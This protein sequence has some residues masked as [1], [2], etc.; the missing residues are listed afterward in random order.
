MIFSSSHLNRV[1]MRG[2]KCPL[3]SLIGQQFKK[4]SNENC[5][6][7]C[8]LTIFKHHFERFTKHNFWLF[9]FHLVFGAL[10]ANFIVNLHFVYT[11]SSFTRKCVSPTINFG[12]TP[13]PGWV[14]VLNI[15]QYNKPIPK[16][17]HVTTLIYKACV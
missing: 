13:G 7:T 1:A 2:T 10:C 5:A 15:L 17:S 16:I 8:V 4:K 6:R 14:I 9:H 12:L 3:P 11:S